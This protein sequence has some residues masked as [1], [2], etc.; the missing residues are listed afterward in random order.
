MNTVFKKWFKM[1]KKKRSSHSVF[2]RATRLSFAYVIDGLPKI[3]KYLNIE[4]FLEKSLKIDSFLIVSA[5]APKVSFC[6]I[7]ARLHMKR[8]PLYGCHT[9]HSG[10]WKT[11]K[12]K[13][14]PQIKIRQIVKLNDKCNKKISD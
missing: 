9:L 12:R 8:Q 1:L 5:H 3:S 7:S 14:D 11:I 6:V 2:I 10:I 13:I 4:G